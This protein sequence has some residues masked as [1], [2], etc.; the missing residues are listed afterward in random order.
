VKLHGILRAAALC[1]TVQAA[2]T[3]HA[4]TVIDGRTAPIIL[5][6][7]GSTAAIAMGGAYPLTSARSDIVFYNPAMARGANGLLF[8]HERYGDAASLTS[9]VTGSTTN[10]TFGVQILD[11]RTESGSAATLD[12]RQLSR[13]GNLRAGEAE[14]VVGYART[15]H[16]L[17]LGAAAKWVQ[18]WSEG[19]GDGMA[20]FDVGFTMNPISGISLGLAVQNLGGENLVNGLAYELPRREAL[21]V[22]TDSHELGPLDV[23]ASGEIHMVREDDLAGGLGV[24]L[25]YWPFQGLTFIA[26]GGARFGNDEL[27]LAGRD[28]NPI[29]K[30]DIPTAG[31]GVT[32][33]RFTLEYAWEPFSGAPDAHRFSVR[34]N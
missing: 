5:T 22:A 28:V 33:K 10:L 15:I 26:R 32:Y 31:A 3:L 23:E 8:S 13:G 9:F 21:M 14:G 18:H 34:I 4:Q 30:H 2:G 29:L 1:C 16:G 27:I 20:A 11:Y 17:R 7:P 19:E 12:E 6:L 25:S 24:E